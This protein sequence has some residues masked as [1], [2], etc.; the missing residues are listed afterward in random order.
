MLSFPQL[1]VEYTIW[2]TW[3]FTGITLLVIGISFMQSS[4]YL[5]H[6][7]ML[8]GIDFCCGQ[9]QAGFEIRVSRPNDVPYERDASLKS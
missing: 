2:F 3:S 7:D 6:G 9:T 8:R 1:A 4:V 5:Y